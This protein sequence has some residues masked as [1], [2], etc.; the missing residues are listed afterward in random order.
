MDITDNLEVEQADAEED[1]LMQDLVQD[2]EAAVESSQEDPHRI[3]ADIEDLV[4]AVDKSWHATVPHAMGFVGSI[5][6][7]END[8]MEVLPKE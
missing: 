2:I 7:A 1:E 5:T 6:S 4:D 8:T 3:L